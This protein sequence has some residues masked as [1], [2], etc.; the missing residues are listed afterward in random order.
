M[1][2]AHGPKVITYRAMIGHEPV[3]VGDVVLL[4]VLQGARDDRHARA[5]ETQLRRF[6]IVSMLDDRLAAAAA[7]HYRQLRARGITLRS[8]ADLIIGTWCIVNRVPLLHDDR[9]FDPM[10][11]HLGLKLA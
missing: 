6:D 10:A 5:V 8:S 3:V 9:D 4:E 2:N 7:S 1:R 11:A